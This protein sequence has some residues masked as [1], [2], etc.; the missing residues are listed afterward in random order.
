MPGREGVPGSFVGELWCGTWGTGATDAGWHLVRDRW[1]LLLAA[2]TMLAAVRVG[3]AVCRRQV[4]RRHAARARWLEIIPPVTA[5][6]AATVGLWRL[7]ATV[8]PAPRRGALRP[9]RIVWEVAAD[10]DGLRCGLW[11]PPGVNPT[12]VVR[13]LHRGWPGVRAA[14][15]APPAVPTVGAVVALAVRPTR[16]EWLPLVDDTTPASRRGMDVAAPEDD[17]LRAVYGGLVSAGRTGGALLQVHLGRAPAHRLRQL[18][19]AMTHPHYARHPRGV[20]RAVL[21]ATLDLITPGP[22]IRRN[23]TGRLDPYAA[24]LARQARVKSTDAPHLLVA[25]QT[26]AVGPTRAAASAAAADVSSGFGLLSPHFTRRR[27]RRGTR[28]VADRWVPGSRMSLAGIG[29]AAA[30]AGL[31]AEPTAYSL[32]GAAS[33]RRAATREVFRT[34]HHATDSPDTTPVEAATVDAPT[35][36]SKP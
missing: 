16:P 29:D 11:L 8:L 36:W 5:T 10:P 21:Q 33:R 18:R 32:P 9:T 14:Q 19:R 27:L 6:P 13:L 25:V 23:P 35:V 28:A 24:E 12:A 22:G 3:W 1:P 26:V 30:L 4:W 17:R 34:T 20:A 2:L 31:P 7:L 15:C